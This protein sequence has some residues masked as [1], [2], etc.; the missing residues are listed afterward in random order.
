MFE[1]FKKFIKRGNPVDMAV[2]I[3]V[4]VAFSAISRSLVDDII[5]PPVGLALG[6]TDFTNLF[7]V[8][9]RGD[10]DGPYGTLADATAAGAVTLNYGIFLNTLINFFFIAVAMFLVVRMVQRMTDRPDEPGSPM[11]QPVDKACPFC[12]EDIP[13]DA[14]RCPRCTSMLEELPAAADPTA[15]EPVAPGG[16]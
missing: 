14:K 12:C 6:D 1:D 10:P 7:V 11:V 15:P 13:I 9:K 5:M 2:G 4:G 16:V 3:S 8:L